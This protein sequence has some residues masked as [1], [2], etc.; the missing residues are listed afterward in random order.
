MKKI[1]HRASTRGSANHGWLQANFS[2][3]FANFYD[4]KREQFGA[5]RVLND[6]LIAPSM[7]FG[8]HPHNNMEIITIP[9]KGILKHKDNMANDWIAVLPEEVQ[10][11][12]AGTGVQHSEI[13]G[14]ASEHLSLFQI[15]ILP[16]KK[17]VTPRY[18][19]KLFDKNERKNKLQV[20]VNSFNADDKNVLKIHQDAQIS[21]IDLDKNNEFTYNLKTQNHGVYVFNISG[22]FQIDGTILNVRDA[23]GIYE[24]TDF[25]INPAKDS[26]LL[27]IEIPM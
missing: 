23:I 12:S 4:S 24:A 18:D 22:E 6:D 3:S 16:E 26:E 14:S 8:T 2:F 10:V 27:L 15:W 9:L 19:Q 1:I 17:G 11:M 21:R 7:G 5:L 13:N 20:L 25:K